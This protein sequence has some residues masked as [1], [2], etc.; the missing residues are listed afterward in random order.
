MQHLNSI[1]SIEMELF[2]GVISSS[3]S[4]KG[5]ENTVLLVWLGCVQSLGASTNPH[6][7]CA[8]MPCALQTGWGRSG[9]PGSLPV[10]AITSALIAASKD[11]SALRTMKLMRSQ[12]RK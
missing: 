3:A 7:N 5:P 12:L 11:E 4:A 1:G 9:G 2:T 8:I 10:S 6:G